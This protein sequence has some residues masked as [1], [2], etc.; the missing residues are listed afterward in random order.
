MSWVV[1]P[2]AG[3]TW[4]SDADPTVGPGVP[5]PLYVFLVRTDDPSLYYKSGL[6]DT[7]WTLIGSGSGGS[8]GTGESPLPDVWA[9][10]N[11]PVGLTAATMPPL[12]SVSFDEI[13]AIKGGSVVGIGWRILGGP[14]TGGTASIK[15]S[16]NGAPLTLTGTSTNASFQNG[17]QVTQADGIDT[18][19][20]GDLIGMQITTDLAFAPANS[21]NIEAWLL[22]KP[23]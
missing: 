22:V 12:V 8:G 6:A 7:A 17:G 2:N 4:F 23:A 19:V 16:K 14:V 3:L 21:L 15:A 13:R 10:E 11:I 9:Y 18:F 5:A 20:A 1:E